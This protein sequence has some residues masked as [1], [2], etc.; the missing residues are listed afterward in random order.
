VNVARRKIDPEA[1]RI[2]KGIGRY[3]DEVEAGAVLGSPSV[4]IGALKG[5][6][7]R[8]DDPEVLERAIAAVKEQ[9]RT[10]TS[11]NR[12]KRTQRVHSLERQLATLR[13]ASNGEAKA[14]F[15]EHAL[16]WATEQRVGYSAF[17][18]MGVPPAVLRD[19]GITRGFE[20]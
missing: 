4:Y 18:A 17:R 11:V 5:F 3:L 6:P 20:P 8:S 12:L 10:G 16:T 13:E 9:A 14:L 2:T 7:M 19:A 15:V 1:L